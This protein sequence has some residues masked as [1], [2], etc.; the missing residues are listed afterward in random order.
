MRMLT[1]I[2]VGGRKGLLVIFRTLPIQS[3]KLHKMLICFFRGR[4]NRFFPNRGLRPIRV[5]MAHQRGDTEKHTQTVH[6]QM[7][8]APAKLWTTM[9]IRRGLP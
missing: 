5:L 8:Q 3:W 2:P 7:S 6:D 1:T 4:A 9:K